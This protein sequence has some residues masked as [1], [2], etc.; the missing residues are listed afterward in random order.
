MW[1]DLILFLAALVPLLSTRHK[2]IDDVP[3]IAH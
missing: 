3:P 1:L 2:H